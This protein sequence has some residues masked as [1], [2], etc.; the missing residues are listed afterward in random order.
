MDVLEVCPYDERRAVI[1]MDEQS[2][3]LL[4]EK[5]ES[6]GMKEQHSKLEDNK[7]VCKG[8]CRVFMFVEPLGA[9]GMFVCPGKGRGRTGSGN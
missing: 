3:Q 8:M 5:R 6:L 2:V 4:G 7:Y 9:G 1:W